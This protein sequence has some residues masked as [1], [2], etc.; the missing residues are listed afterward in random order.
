M[1]QKRKS[2]ASALACDLLI[3]PVLMLELFW[4]KLAVAVILWGKMSG[5]VPPPSSLLNLITVSFFPLLFVCLGDNHRKPCDSLWHH[6]CLQFHFSYLCKSP[7]TLVREYFAAKNSPVCTCFANHFLVLCVFFRNSLVLE[8]WGQV[9]ENYI[10]GSN[11]LLFFTNV[12]WKTQKSS[13]AWSKAKSL[14]FCLN[15]SDMVSY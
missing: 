15:I 8:R 11:I 12:P 3:S 5:R 7:G 13:H 4:M 2:Q 14:N 1:P 6:S 9:L 10:L